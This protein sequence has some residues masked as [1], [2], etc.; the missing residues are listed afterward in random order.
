MIMMIIP[1]K[2]RNVDVVIKHVNTVPL[3]SWVI[4]LQPPPHL[5]ATVLVQT[6]IDDIFVTVLHG[7]RIKAEYSVFSAN[8]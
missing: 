2:E 8:F 3:V 7:T 1:E 5:S 4:E 6:F